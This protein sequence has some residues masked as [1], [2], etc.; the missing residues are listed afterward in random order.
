VNSSI[1][2]NDLDLQQ[3][4]RSALMGMGLAIELSQN[5]PHPNPICVAG[6]ER[7]ESIERQMESR[8]RVGSNVETADCRQSFEIE[9]EARGNHDEIFA[10]P[11]PVCSPVYPP[12]SAVDRRLRI[13]PWLLRRITAIIT[14]NNA[15]IRCTFGN[16]NTGLP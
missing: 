14:A 6:A 12:V 16:K 11:R 8:H 13:L 4:A 2:S 1:G 5:C 10:G 3:I 9:G 7:F 15:E